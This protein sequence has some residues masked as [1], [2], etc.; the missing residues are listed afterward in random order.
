MQHTSRGR[1][2]SWLVIEAEA[3]AQKVQLLH[4]E[5]FNSGVTIASAIRAV[6]NI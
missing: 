3:R 1:T 2:A 6:Q 4:L 5:N